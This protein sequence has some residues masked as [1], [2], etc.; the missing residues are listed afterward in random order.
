MPE[1][2]GNY[3]VPKICVSLHLTSECNNRC[4]QCYNS[5]GLK[6]E[7]K[8]TTAEIRDLA[9][10]L[11]EVYKPEKI[12][13]VL[14]G[15][16]PTLRDDIG[17]ILA[18]FGES[19]QFEMVMFSNGA[20][21]LKCLDLL[22]KYDV[23]GAF[24]FYGLFDVHDDWAGRKG[25]FKDLC[26]AAVVL[27]WRIRFL[28]LKENFHQAE[29]IAEFSKRLGF[30]E[31]GLAR[32]VPQGRGRDI[33]L[34]SDEEY[35]NF[36]VSLL[37]F[38]VEASGFQEKDLAQFLEERNGNYC[39]SSFFEEEFIISCTGDVFT[40]CCF[41]SDDQDFS[42]K[43]WLGNVR[44]DDWESLRL[45]A[46]NLNR[47]FNF[48]KIKSILRENKIKFLYPMDKCL[49]CVKFGGPDLD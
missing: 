1:E 42:R 43:F 38:G 2:S 33:C 21:I 12:R 35:K 8:L 26:M 13:L 15:G 11:A 5:S 40:T 48:E 44:T 18:I 22:N 34:I 39:A 46:Q 7:N 32:P 31:I 28:A 29:L 30:T 14:S 23:S 37:N 24:T 49:Y 16:E 25:A 10:V 17:E 20:R 6:K 47:R 3:V 19:G 9:K 45:K 41:I 36:Q 4:K 27:R